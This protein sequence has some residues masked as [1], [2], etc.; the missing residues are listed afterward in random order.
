MSGQMDATT[1]VYEI[2]RSIV[3]MH[4]AGKYHCGIYP[5]TS[6]HPNALSIYDHLWMPI[7]NA[8]S[9][10][11]QFKE[12]TIVHVLRCDNIAG[13]IVIQTQGIDCQVSCKSL[14][15]ETKLARIKTTF[16][17]HLELCGAAS[18]TKFL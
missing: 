16:V 18:A 17:P 5:I 13:T 9:R 15:S 1:T 12:C 10:V 3:T 4:R 2:I 11:T 7:P 14:T 6:R 8:V